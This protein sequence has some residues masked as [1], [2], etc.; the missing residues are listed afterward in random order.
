MDPQGK[1][2]PK[3]TKSARQV[4]TRSKTYYVDFYD[5]GKRK[6]V[7]LKTKSLPQA[8]KN[9]RAL[10]RQREQEALGIRGQATDQLARPLEAHLQEWRSS[11]LASD[12]TG[13]HVLTCFSQVTRIAAEAKWQR[14]PDITADSCQKVLDQLRRRDGL[15]PQTLNHHLTH[16]KQFCR[17]AVHEGRLAANPVARLRKANVAVDRRHDRRCPTEEEIVK[18]FAYLYGPQLPRTHRHAESG[19]VIRNG[20]NGPAR[21]MGYKVAMGTGLRAQELRSLSRESFQ[22]EGDSPTVTVQAAYS[23]HRREDRLPVPIWLAQELR[24][25]FAAG[26]SCWEKL[27]SVFPGRALKNDLADAGIAYRQGGR[28]FDFHSLRVYYISALASQPGIDPK[29]LMDLCRHTDP[30]LTLAI[31]AKVKQERARQAVEAIPRPGSGRTT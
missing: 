16:V 22:L 10:L 19:C 3:G 30:R 14:L 25:W 6:H 23:K 15:S 31:Y 21:A 4:R 26:G 2:V 17:W 29:T 7:S 27:P 20:M 5:A 1:Q 24:E 13:K 18:L 8:W 11:L 12:V 28:Y 9:L